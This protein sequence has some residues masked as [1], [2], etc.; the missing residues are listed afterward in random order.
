MNED[1]KTHLRRA[2]IALDRIMH[3]ETGLHDEVKRQIAIRKERRIASAIKKE[4]RNT[5]E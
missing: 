3:N 2:A 4:T 1:D 5:D